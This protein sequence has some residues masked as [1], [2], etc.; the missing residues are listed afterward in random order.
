MKI[1]LAADAIG[2]DGMAGCR[3]NP[4]KV[5]RLSIKSP[6]V[7]ENLLV[8][9]GWGEST[10]VKI[11][12]DDVT[13]R[14][15]EIHSGRHNG[16]LVVGKNVVI[17]SCKIHHVLAGT[18][19]DQK[20]AHGIAGQPTKLVIRNCEISMVSGDCLQF[21]PGRGPWDDVLVENCTFKTG[22]LETDAAGFKKGERPGENAIDT[23]QK[24]S[25][26][27]SRLTIRNCLFEGWKQPGQVS[28]L[29]ALNLKN[30]V[31]VKV[32]NC[33]F[34]D[35]EICLRLRGGEGD[36]GGALVRVERC[37]VYESA[38]ALR[39]EDKIRDLKIHGLGIGGGIGKKV[40]YAGGGA[41]TGFAMSGDFDPPTFEEAKK[42]G[43]MP[44]EQ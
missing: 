9:G 6:G 11:V 29:A 19:K 15:C 42:S 27:R 25:N 44:H 30:H 37:A 38:V 8:D 14:N 23:K 12:A 36:Y 22:P 16:V 18:F 17:E 33:L 21:D 40:V 2:S 20:D 34:R 43:L 26:P 4:K 31:Q 28:N 39:I 3:E 41:G 10:L 5:D 32:E 24:A 35:N 1:S 7:Y 13:L